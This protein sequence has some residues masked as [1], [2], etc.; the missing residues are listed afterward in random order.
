MSQCS[1]IDI[2]GSHPQICTQFDGDVG[3]AIPIANILTINGMTVANATYAEPIWVSASGNTVVVN[4]Q[5]GTER[6]G[7]P[8]DK[9]DAGLVSFDDTNF[10]VDANGYV[11]LIGGGGAGDVKTNTGDDAVAVA[12]D[13]AGNFG[14]IGLTVANATHAKPVFFK[15]SATANAI[16]LDIQVGV[17]ITGAPIDKHD[18]GL[19]SYDDTQFAVDANGYV[20]LVGGAG[21]PAIQTLTSDDPTI[22]GPNAS[23][24]IGITGEA[25]ANATNAKPLFVDAGANALNAEIQVGAAVTGAPIDKNDAG[26]VSFDDTDFAVSTHG[27]VTLVGGGGAGDVKTNTGDDAVAVAPDGA[28]DFGW[29]G[30]TVANATHAKPVYFKDSA[31]ANAIDLDVQVATEITGAP[32]DA[33]DAGL[34]SFNDT[35]FTV[36]ANGYVALVGGANLPVAQTI[37]GD[38]GGA[39]SPDANGNWNVLGLAESETR[40]S[41]STLSIFSPRCCEWIVDPTLNNGTHQTITAAMADAVSGDTIIV[42]P[43]TYTENF[44]LK[45]GVDLAGLPTRK[46]SSSTRIIGKITYTDTGQASI[47]NLSLTTNLDYAISLTGA[48]SGTLLLKNCYLR[49]ED[50][51]CVLVNNTNA[52][53]HLWECMTSQASTFA[54]FT[55]TAGNIS[56]NYCQTLNSGGTVAPSST[57]EKALTFRFSEI[58]FP[59]SS[60]STGTIGVLHCRMPMASLNITAITTAGTGVSRVIHSEIESGSASAI[61]VGS[62]TELFCDESLIISNNTNAITGAGTIRYNCSFRGTSRLVNTTAKINHAMNTGTISFTNGTSYIGSEMTTTQWGTLYYDGTKVVNGAVGTSGQVW[63][64]NGAGS[65]PTFQNASGGGMTWTE[66]TG[67]SQSASVNNGYISNNAAQVVVTL[68]ATASVGDEVEI[69]G[70]GAGG[71]RLAQNAGQTIHYLSADSTA[72]VGGYI[73][74]TQR[75]NCIKVRCITANTNWV[76]VVPTGNLGIV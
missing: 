41:G 4:A 73:E 10:A 68:P 64:S 49:A 66:V 76:V 43:G 58:N 11:T 36:D 44:T 15:D 13:G 71:W 63:T 51:N 9:N 69:N 8:A 1:L 39:L 55:G 22:V 12:P 18:A 54:M 32:I 23:G 46:S 26:I 14:W 7:A 20:T 29:I 21:L 5:V 27:Y 67:T 24:N 6:T 65:A 60:S 70:K 57:A 28:G 30:L 35:Q 25:V 2:E 34:A 38:T 47:V 61:S 17:A 3:S 52:N 33:N 16:D 72:G 53:I 19:S 45:A 62:G 31:T 59:L 75:Y 42:R 40:G 37:T 74:S 50:N 48:N 56:G